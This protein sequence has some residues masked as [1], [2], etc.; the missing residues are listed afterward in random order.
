MV[1]ISPSLLSANFLHLEK[2]IQMMEECGVNIFHMDVMDGSFVPNISYG[3]MILK[4]VDSI[5]KVPMDTHLMIREPNRYF[6]VF[7]QYNVEYLTI[8]QE[9][10]LHL[11]RDIARIKELG[12]KAGVALNPATSP[13]TLRYVIRDLDLVLVMSVNP[14]FGGQKFISSQLEKIKEIKDMIRRYHS[15][16]IVE[17]DGGIGLNNLAA[18]IDAGADMIVSGSSLFKGSFRDNYSKFMDIVNGR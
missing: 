14:G 7:A 8:H 12:M 6:E 4:A 11:E 2:D 9:A 17:I 16:A 5:S 18:V 3:P 13:E 1:R 10:S 15:N